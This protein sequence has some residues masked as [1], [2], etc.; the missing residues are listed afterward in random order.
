MI[1][2]VLAQLLA[3]VLVCKTGAFYLL[4]ETGW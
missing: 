3:V 1:A 2:H 4:A